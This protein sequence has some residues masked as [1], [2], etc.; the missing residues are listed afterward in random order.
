M[1]K[2]ESDWAKLTLR[3]AQVAEAILWKEEARR[4]HKTRLKNSGGQVRGADHLRRTNLDFQT[5][6]PDQLEARGARW[7]CIS[8]EQITASREARKWPILS[9]YSGQSPATARQGDRFVSY[10]QGADQIL[11]H[12]LRIK[13]DLFTQGWPDPLGRSAAFGIEDN[14]SGTYHPTIKK[15]MYL[16]SP[17]SMAALEHT[18]IQRVNIEL[19]ALIHCQATHRMWEGL[20]LENS[21]WKPY[22]QTISKNC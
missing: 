6:G 13:W 11:Q 3:Q 5:M 15:A 21:P 19:M 10:E 8:F 4:S 20:E 1:S 16:A 2:G 7:G 12:Y 18:A 9:R 17:P 14:I 22:P